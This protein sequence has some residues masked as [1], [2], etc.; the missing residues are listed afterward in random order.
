ME[1]KK[2][3]YQI[4]GSVKEATKAFRSNVNIKVVTYGI[5][6]AV[7]IAKELEPDIN[8]F[9]I[10]LKETIDVIDPEVI[11]DLFN[12]KEEDWWK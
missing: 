9:Q 1:K 12:S 7:K 8:I 2:K 4:M 10:N 5:E 11:L 3:L 6:S